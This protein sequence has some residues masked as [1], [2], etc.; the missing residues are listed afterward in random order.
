M[1]TGVRVR[2]S[3]VALSSPERTVGEARE[4]HPTAR[5]E[6]LR[7]PRPD[8][9]GGSCGG[10]NGHFRQ[11]GGMASVGG[12]SDILKIFFIS[13]AGQLATTIAGGPE[14]RLLRPKLTA[15]LRFD[16]GT[17]DPVTPGDRQALRIQ[18]GGHPVIIVGPVDVV[19]DVLFAGPDDLHRT[20]DLFGDPHRL[21]DKIDLQSPTPG[22]ALAAGP[23]LWRPSP[24]RD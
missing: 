12:H 20:I 5:F 7:Q 6:L 3:G 9:R 16:R 17:G 11:S 15:P 2:D 21:G 8:R 23:Q 14:A 22:L 19:P 13:V 4:R 18:S 1:I 24:G 10:P